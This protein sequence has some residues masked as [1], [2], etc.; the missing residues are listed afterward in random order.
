MITMQPTYTHARDMRDQNIYM[1]VSHTSHPLRYIH[2]YIHIHTH[3]HTHTHIS[4]T[5]M[6][7]SPQDLSFK[8]P[9]RRAVRALAEQ[10]NAVRARLGFAERERSPSA[11]STNMAWQVLSMS[12]WLPTRPRLCF[13]FGC[14]ILNT[15]SKASNRYIL[16]TV[17]VCFIAS[18]SIM[19][20]RVLTGWLLDQM[21]CHHS[22]C[23]FCIW[24]YHSY[25]VQSTPSN[26]I[27]SLPLTPTLVTP[28]LKSCG[29]VIYKLCGDYHASEIPFVYQVACL[30]GCEWWWTGW[31]GETVCWT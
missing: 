28:Q 20:L 31:G 7:C 13:R 14:I 18:C 10:G 23:Q 5:S 30:L 19:C 2:V 27:I 11:L 26:T 15:N 6:H 1:L 16:A 3:T 21:I 25:H 17:F 8:C 29:T 24:S 4:L 9:A 12:H 22:Y